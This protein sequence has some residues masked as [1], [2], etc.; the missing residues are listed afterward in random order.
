MAIRYRSFLQTL[1]ASAVLYAATVGFAVAGNFGLPHRVPFA[2]GIYNPWFGCIPPYG[3]QDPFQL[4]LELERER[5]M[6]ELRERAARSEPGLQGSAEGPWGGQRYVPPATPESNIQ[7]A[8][9]GAS[10]LR[11]EYEQST[12][13]GGKQSPK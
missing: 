3:C 11:P 12:T 10:Q 6:Q 7:P 5:R 13:P 1:G 9:R 8:Y 4:R 2:L